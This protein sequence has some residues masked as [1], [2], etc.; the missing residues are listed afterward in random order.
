MRIKEVIARKI[1]DSRKQGTIEISV[2]TE[3]GKFISSAPSGK[4]RGRFEAKPYSSNLERDIILGYTSSGIH[5]DDF[6]FRIDNQPI[7]RYGSCARI[8]PTIPISSGKQTWME[9]MI[10]LLN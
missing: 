5:K 10:M 7:K 1:L 8:H 3:K 2:L 9:A 4:S 6:D